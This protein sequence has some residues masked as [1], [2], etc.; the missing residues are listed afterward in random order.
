MS[1]VIKQ[2]NYRTVDLYFIKTYRIFFLLILCS[3]VA[4]YMEVDIGSKHSIRA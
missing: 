1:H 3:Q 2:S 4:I